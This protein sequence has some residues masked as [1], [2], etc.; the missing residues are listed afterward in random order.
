MT[1]RMERNRCRHEETDRVHWTPRPQD[2]GQ[3][4]KWP[5]LPFVTCNTI[6]RSVDCAL[7]LIEQEVWRAIFPAEIRNCTRCN[8]DNF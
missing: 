2:E 1:R 7:E 5:S 4:Q 3:Q 8:S 6:A